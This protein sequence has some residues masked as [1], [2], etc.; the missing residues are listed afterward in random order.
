MGKA[1]VKIKNSEDNFDFM[2]TNKDNIENVL[3]NSNTI[4]PIINDLVNRTN[5]IVINSYQ[6]IKLYF[7]FLYDTNDIFPEINIQFI[8]DVFKVV[9]FSTNGKGR[10][11]EDNM[12]EQLKTLTNFYKEHYIGTLHNNKPIIYDKLP[13]ILA[14]EA[15]DMVT[16]I[17]NNI[18]GHFIDHLN[19]YVNYTFKLKEQLSEITKNTKDKI[20]RKEIHKNLYQ[21]FNNI[22]KDLI[23]FEDDFTSN[24]KYHSWILKQKLKLFPG[25]LNLK[26]IVFIMI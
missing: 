14:Y 2:K 10:Y 21:E 22:K 11:R 1:K 5:K 26:R 18:Q 9:T 24:P 15:I 8:R 7:S 19:K 13:Y 6:F 3:R 4:L 23:T 12:P 20:I 25:K 16:N 17:N